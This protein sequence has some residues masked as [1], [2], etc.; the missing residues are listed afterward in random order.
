MVNSQSNCSP[1]AASAETQAVT[2]TWRCDGDDDHEDGGGGG[3]D[4]ED[5]DLEDHLSGGGSDQ[6]GEHPPECVAT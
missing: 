2:W 4:H 6:V 3:D 1:G 5:E